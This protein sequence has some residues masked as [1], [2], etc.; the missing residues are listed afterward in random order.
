MAADSIIVQFVGS[1]LLALL[2]G[3]WTALPPDEFSPQEAPIVFAAQWPVTGVAG[4]RTDHV[5]LLA[6]G[7]IHLGA[8]SSITFRPDGS[9]VSLAD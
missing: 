8:V 4:M 6:D 2:T 3:S 1:L 5:E 7:A 9:L